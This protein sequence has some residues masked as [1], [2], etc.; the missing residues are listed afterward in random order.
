MGGR[1]GGREGQRGRTP[2]SVL[3]RT[4]LREGERETRAR[5]RASLQKKKKLTTKTPILASVAQMK[6]SS[7]KVVETFFVFFLE[8]RGA[9]KRG[10]VWVSSA[11]FG[12]SSDAASAFLCH[13][14]TPNSSV[15]LPHSRGQTGREKKK[16]EREG[17]GLCLGLSLCS[18]HTTLGYF[19]PPPPRGFRR[20]VFFVT[21]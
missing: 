20:G 10:R 1:E 2:A 21:S 17:G 3:E 14:N 13:T 12:L 9:E 11:L 6:L 8:G 16:S 18:L 15:H 7:V 5:K 19:I 4:F